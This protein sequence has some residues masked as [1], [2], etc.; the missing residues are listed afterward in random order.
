MPDNSETLKFVFKAQD[1]LSPTLDKQQ[2]GLTATTAAYLKFGD[3][4]RTIKYPAD[5]FQAISKVLSL[6][7]RGSKVWNSFSTEF[8]KS[9]KV[10]TEGMSNQQRGMALYQSQMDVLEQ[11]IQGYRTVAEQDIE[12]SSEA[13]TAI[14]LLVIERQK[15]I[16]QGPQDIATGADKVTADYVMATKSLKGFQDA[17]KQGAGSNA[18]FIQTLDRLADVLERIDGVGTGAAK[19]VTAATAAATKAAGGGAPVAS[20]QKAYVA[21]EK[22][23][24]EGRATGGSSPADKLAE[25][26][27]KFKPVEKYR[28]WEKLMDE[29]GP[30]TAAAL[31]GGIDEIKPSMSAAILSTVLKPFE[32]I[33]A[34]VKGWGVSIK[35]FMG[36]WK[37][38]WK[39]GGVTGV[40]RKAFDGAA[41]G[42]GKKAGEIAGKALTKGLGFLK[43]IGSAILGPF[44][45][46]LSITKILEPAIALMERA[47]L[48]LLIPL[49]DMFQQ[50][51]A[52]F[53]PVIQ[54]LVPIIVELVNA[55]LPMF[56]DLVKQV[57]PILVELAQMALPPLLMVLKTLMPIVTNVAK[58]ILNLAQSV[59]PMLSSVLESLVGAV[60]WVFNSISDIV[61]TLSFGYID[62]GQVEVAGAPKASA[63]TGGS[64]NAQGMQQ[65]GGAYAAAPLVMDQDLTDRVVPGQGAEGASQRSAKDAATV[66]KVVAKTIPPAMKREPTTNDKKKDWRGQQELIVSAIRNLETTLARLF[67][68]KS[69]E[70]DSG[71]PVVI[72]FGGYAQYTR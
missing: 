52:S 11:S 53:F 25:A 36:E 4:L 30:R 56:L 10:V 9:M 48:P 35:E 14:A 3:S 21:A 1:E 17:Q 50:I 42:F 66:A 28:Q 15:L 71:P 29:L 23:R 61:K 18:K 58:A 12:R 69:R 49:Q 72:D 24:S 38:T 62:L 13:A 39:A 32:Q 19:T 45:S 40:L 41:K 67:E 64:T 43:D 27:S 33:G 5:Q 2:K 20:A 47:L 55:A 6:A 59:L 60:T 16:D 57:A 70:R 22:S 54:Q 68:K 7:E 46:I 63:P 8:Q 37:D 26:F 44:K 65:A 31:M 51:A 34:T